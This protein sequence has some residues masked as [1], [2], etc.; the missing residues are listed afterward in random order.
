MRDARMAWLQAQYTRYAYHSPNDMP[1]DPAGTVSAGPVNP[2]VAAEID[3][4]RRR[5]KLARDTAKAGG[6]N[7]N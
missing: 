1:D 3:A 5:V 4:I 7:G 2:E 6:A